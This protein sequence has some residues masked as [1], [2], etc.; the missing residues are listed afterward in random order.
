MC[1]AALALFR[2]ALF[3]LLTEP[4]ERVGLGYERVAKG[5]TRVQ[6]LC[7]PVAV[8]QDLLTLVGG[9]ITSVVQEAANA[10]ES[11]AWW[12]DPS[13]GVE[14]SSTITLASGTLPIAFRAEVV[15]ARGRCVVKIGV[16]K[17]LVH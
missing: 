11:M 2:L 9:A 10:V 15:K 14:F 4:G 13:A 12:D 16:V 17:S 7:C 3:G 1:H 6:E 8:Q 5:P